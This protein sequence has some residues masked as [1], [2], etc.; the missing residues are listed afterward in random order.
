MLAKDL[1]TEDIPPL[2]TS[3]LGK[4]ALGFMN[5][6]HVIH[7][8]IVN[9]K[10]FL[11]LISEQDI[12]DLNEPDSP[13]GNHTLSLINPFVQSSQHLYEVINLVARLKL[14]IIPVVDEEHN[15]I[16][17]ITL[18]SIIENL[19]LQSS[20]KEPG[21]II[22]LEMAFHDYSLS[23]IARIVESNEAKILSVF[24]NTDS[25]RRILKLTIKVN[26]LD[27]KH[28]VA[29]FERFNYKVIETFMENEH[30]DTFKDRYDILMK[31][32]NM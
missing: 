22:L 31:Y 14:S 1:I 8:P 6:F 10:Q 7:L 24:V 12:I 18:Q 30:K 20:I 29:T 23:E 25:S 5:E 27:L 32:L 4:E 3:D 13:L 11:G 16:G 21:G 28:I 9:N 2:K 26:R 19:S 17:I 15:Y